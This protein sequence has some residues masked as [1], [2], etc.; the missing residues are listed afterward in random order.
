MEQKHAND[1]EA[2]I[3]ALPLLYRLVMASANVRAAGLTKT[4]L[5]ILT[6]LASQGP[7]RMSQIADYISSLKGQATRAVSALEEEGYISRYTD[8]EKRTQVYVKLTETGEQF[9][10]RWRDESR[11]NLKRILND[12]VSKDEQVRLY[13]AAAEITDIL[14]KK[15]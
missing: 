8:T 5:I 3:T 10:S 15:E 2:L 12:S 13:Q 1:E 6:S 4:Q 7:L 11:A 14:G 9:V